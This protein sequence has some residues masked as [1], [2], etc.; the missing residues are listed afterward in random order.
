[1][2]IASWVDYLIAAP[3][4]FLFG[5]LGGLFALKKYREIVDRERRYRITLS[6]DDSNKEDE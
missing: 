5:F 6:Y 3:I 2:V 4:G 1:M